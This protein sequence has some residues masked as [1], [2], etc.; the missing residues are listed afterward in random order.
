[1]QGLVTTDRPSPAH[2]QISLVHEQ[3]MA[4]VSQRETASREAGLET[5]KMAGRGSHSRERERERGRRASSPAI[6]IQT[7]MRGIRKDQEPKSKFPNSSASPLSAMMSADLQQPAHSLPDHQQQSTTVSQPQR[8]KRFMGNLFRSKSVSSDLG[9]DSGIVSPTTVAENSPAGLPIFPPSTVTVSKSVTSNHMTSPRRARSML[10]PG[11]T[12]NT[13]EARG[14]HLSSVTLSKSPRDMSSHGSAHPGSVTPRIRTRGERS[15][16]PATRSIHDSTMD[17]EMDTEGNVGGRS[18]FSHSPKRSRTSGDT[19]DESSSFSSEAGSTTSHSSVP[20]QTDRS[21]SSAT[22]SKA[23][24]NGGSVS[25]I[26]WKCRSAS[27][28]RF[29]GVVDGLG[30]G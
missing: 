27:S 11:V 28:A 25:A 26:D 29:D 5:D 12:R 1:M 13:A 3:A 19:R 21:D 22:S 17:L 10:P 24:P 9:R 16:S 23:N 6:S 7:P 15:T 20:D 14:D 8:F 2:R 4:E 18:R 30:V